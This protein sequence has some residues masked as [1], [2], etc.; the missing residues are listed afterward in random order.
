MYAYNISLI[1]AFFIGI[2]LFTMKYLKVSSESLSPTMFYAIATISFLLWLLSRF[3]IYSASSTLPITTIHILLN[4]SVIVSTLLSIF[5]YQ[6][7]HGR[8][9]LRGKIGAELLN[10]RFDVFII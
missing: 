4:L 7:S 10:Q 2:H 3:C 8:R 5:V 6:T 9:I 1:A